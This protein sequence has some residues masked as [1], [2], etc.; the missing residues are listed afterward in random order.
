MVETVLIA[1]RG[2]I[3]VRIIRACK[4]M[5]IKTVA[6]FSTSDALSQHVKLAD[7]AYCLGSGTVQETY[8]NIPKIIDIAVKAKVDA[9]HPGYGFLSENAL[10]AREVINHNIVFIGP[11]PE[12]LESLGDKVKARKIAQEVGIPVVPGSEGYVQDL[13]DA[14]AVVEK[15]GYPI[16]IKAAFGGGGK[17]MEIVRSEETLEIALMGSQSIAESFFGSKEVFIEKFI[18]APRHIEIQFI[19]DNF[20]NVIHLGDR[21]C[22]IQRS[23]QKI[24]EEAP[25]FLPDEIRNE[26]GEKVCQLAKK[27]GYSNAGTAEFLWKD[28]QIYFNEVN[29][30]IQ[31]EHPVTEMITGVDLVVEQLRVAKG[32]KLNYTQEDI[33]INGSAIEYRINAEDPSTFLPQS[34]KIEQLIVP[35]IYHVRFDTFIYPSYEVSN[36]YDSL[37]GKLIVWGKSRQ[38][39]IERS[40]IAFS[41]LTI[42]GLITNVDF[43]KAIIETKEFRERA[44]STDFI[45]KAAIKEKIQENEEMKI[46][47]IYAFQRRIGETKKAILLNQRKK[48]R[49]IINRWK[50]RSKLEQARYLL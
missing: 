24:I 20:G 4:L 33:T 8:L 35:S 44:V 10:F 31:V 25:S 3:A 28:G 39:A 11:P 14:K 38:D 18:E 40:K 12:V 2:E 13:E 23:H 6:I 9:V 47:A 48:E 27:L 15:I 30:R 5:N 21:E 41:E 37:L 43:H 22:S 32:E 29:P 36:E 45:E 34:G 7:E 1:N 49:G 50:Q 42:S 16:I 19:A 46:A 26:L 17:G